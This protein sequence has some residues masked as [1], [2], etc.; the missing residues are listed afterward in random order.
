[1]KIKRYLLLLSMLTA[2]MLFCMTSISATAPSY[3]FSLQSDG[4]TEQY[5]VPGD[6]ITVTFTL[7]RTDSTEAYP[8]Y[9]MQNE[10]RYDSTFFELVEDSVQPGNGVFAKDVVI[11][12]REHELYMNYL[13]LSGGVDWDVSTVVG[14][15][16][17]RV[18]GSSGSSVIQCSDCS[19]S[20]PDGSGSYPFVISDLTVTV[21]DECMV[22]FDSCG[23]T[24][25]SEQTVFSGKRVKIP[26]MPARD[27][28]LFTG[29]YSDAE[30]TEKWHF[31]E[32][33]TKNLCL[34][35][36]WESDAG[37]ESLPFDDIRAEDW[38]YDSI[39]YVYKSDLMNGVGETAFSPDTETSRAMAVTILWRME[40][41]PVVQNSMR[42]E[43]V[44]AD[45]WYT[46]AVRWASSE[47]IVNGYSETVFGV[48]DIITR[49]QMA[50]ILCRYAAYKGHDTAAETDLTAFRDVQTVS[51]WAADA[52]KWSVESGLI[53][54]V[55]D[56]TLHPL[57]S[58]TRAQTATILMRFSIWN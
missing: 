41:S 13:S 7:E 6:I 3:R 49:E 34:Y 58:A 43:D 33:V 48:N 35:A 44:A 4:K 54:G 19:V 29:W 27:G 50:A 46:E 23:G 30:C 22:S 25:I 53:Q 21:S 18:I 51:D 31:S 47:G 14:S 56:D 5:A 15:F 28:Y 17:L 40:G 1:M 42:F 8:M 36:G 9:A 55:G 2:L 26:A 20:R 10:I 11:N 45:Q 38:Y 32:P 52:I 37:E 16:Q 39:R 57:G 12:D 24:P